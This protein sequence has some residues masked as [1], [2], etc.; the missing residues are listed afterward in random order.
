MKTYS[1]FNITTFP[2][3]NEII[4][5]L[6]WQLDIDGIN[7]TD[8]GLIAFADSSKNIS[9]KEIHSV[10]SQAVTEKLILKFDV[11]EQ[12]LEY[13]NWNEEYERKVNVIEVTDTIIIKPSFKDYK[14]KPGQLIITID[15]KMSF[16]TGEHATTRLVI[17]LI[18][19]NITGNEKVLDVGS[20]TGVLGI[21]A[22]MLGAKSS[23]CI[24]NDEWC[25][26]NGDE[27]VLAN[28]LKNKVEIRLAE[29]NQVAE[30][31]FD[32]I[33]ANINKHILKDIAEDLKVRLQLSGKLIL[34]GL[35][36]SDEADIVAHYS[37]L[38][39][40][41]SDKTTLDE[42]CTLVFQIQ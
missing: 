37:G 18:E 30:N 6:L 5:G 14:A 15:P 11:K 13:K 26:L 12:I 41:L 33:V 27:N 20:G 9:L 35:L 21:C 1:E 24:D 4:S 23:L 40:K 2:I 8:N 22:V 25:L 16:G 17:Q 39:F 38:D 28:N 19:K 31:N 3:I 29:I 42:W 32:L 10:L 34:S 36:I 7:E